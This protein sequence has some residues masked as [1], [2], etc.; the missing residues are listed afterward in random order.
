MS[1]EITHDAARQ[2]Y[3][4]ILDGVEGYL[5][6]ER[7]QPGVRHI[8]HTIVPDAIGGR[9]I[10]KRLVN[11]ILDDIKADGEKVTSACWYASALIDKTPAWAALKA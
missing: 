1:A 9:G 2:R 8:T 4:L 6:Y 3:S 11:R 7:R 5:T 10:G